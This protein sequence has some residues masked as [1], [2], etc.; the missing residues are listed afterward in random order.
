MQVRDRVV[1]ITG[2]AHMRRFRRR[3]FPD[4]GIMDLGSGG[5]E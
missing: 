3:L 5:D 2:G 1:L 4:D